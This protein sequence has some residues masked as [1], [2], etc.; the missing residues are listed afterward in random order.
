MSRM[1]WPDLSRD[2]TVVTGTSAIR[3]GSVS[4]DAGARSGVAAGILSSAGARWRLPADDGFPVSG[5]PGL[6]TSV[7]LTILVSGPTM[8]V[9]CAAR[10]RESYATPRQTFPS[11]SRPDP[12]GPTGVIE[13]L[14]K[15]YSPKLAE[16]E[17]RWFVL[18]AAGIPLGRLSSLAAR[19]LMGKHKPTYA[20]H[21]DT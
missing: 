14:K 9:L 12:S 17:H 11:Q 20:T 10:R 7:R 4:E 15:T 19:L 13:M 3:R 5:L 2:A 21:I 1:V 6:R 18:D 8:W 16:I